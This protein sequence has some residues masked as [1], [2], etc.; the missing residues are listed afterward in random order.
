MSKQLSRLTNIP[1]SIARRWGVEEDEEESGW[2][3]QTAAAKF[4]CDVAQDYLHAFAFTT[5]SANVWLLREN[6]QRQRNQYE[7]AIGHWWSRPTHLTAEGD[8]VVQISKQTL[9]AILHRL[10]TL[11]SIV[12]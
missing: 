10:T 11:E 3:N 12:G 8:E 2:E 9:S 4:V 5:G 7:R 1:G 6:I